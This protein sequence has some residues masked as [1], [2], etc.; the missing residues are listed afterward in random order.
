MNAR[1][2][3]RAAVVAGVAVL[4]LGMAGAATASAASASAP[5]NDG[6]S[7]SSS[8]LADV[9]VDGL[10]VRTGPGTAN[11]A[12]GLVYQGDQVQV[13]DW[14]NDRTGQRWNQVMLT[15]DSRGGL[16]GGYVGWVTD[17]YLYRS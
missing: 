9:T 6:Y 1:T 4:G 15:R 13:L 16:P 5:A 17:S 12:T 2:G 14:T 11:G 7:W 3:I 10:R 8:D